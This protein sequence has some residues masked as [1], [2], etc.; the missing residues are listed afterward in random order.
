[1]KRLILVYLLVLPAAAFAQAPGSIAV[2]A[3]AG[4]SDCNVVDEGSLVTLYFFHL[5]TDGATA[6]GWMLD[7]SETGWTFLSQNIGWGM[8]CCVHTGQS[9]GYGSCET[10]AI[11]LGNANFLG[12]NVAPCTYISIVPDPSAPTGKIEAIDCS[13]TKVFPTGGQAV[14]NATPDCLC[15]V[16][17]QETTWGGVKALYR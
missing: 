6:S 13:E 16:P 5:A 3:D 11:Y 12:S 8:F 17:V 7:I 4:G 1:M 10:G 14:V 15:N 9:I 2:F